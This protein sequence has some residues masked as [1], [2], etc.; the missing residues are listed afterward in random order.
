[1]ND[2]QTTEPP[3]VIVLYED[4]E[5]K[6]KI[7]GR[8]T[9]GEQQIYWE[10]Q[11]Q[12]LGDDVFAAYLAEV[13]SD[14]PL[15]A[16]LRGA[17]GTVNGM[18]AA[19]FINATPSYDRWWREHVESEIQGPS[20]PL[21]KAFLKWLQDD[22]PKMATRWTA[23][24][25]A[26]ERRLVVGAGPGADLNPE[27]IEQMLTD[28]EKKIRA[29]L[30]SQ[31]FGIDVFYAYMAETY[32]G[33]FQAPALRAA[34]GTRNGVRAAVFFNAIPIHDPFWCNRI[35]ERV[36]GND[37]MHE[38]AFLC[39]VC[40]KLPHRLVDCWPPLHAASGNRLIAPQKLQLSVNKFR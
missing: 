35:S 23:Y 24:A 27:F 19:G 8:P 31:D 6:L 4:G 34:S 5:M 11:R 29:E 37:S 12:G 14:L 7:P 26:I 15:A 33:R 3:R 16:S 21:E 13:Y 1:M 18:N 10:I 32:S 9:D 2:S 39:W 17:S 40:N 25:R 36:L 30:E 28:G 20:T 38:K 22:L